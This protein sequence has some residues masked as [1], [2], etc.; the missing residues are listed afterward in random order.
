[1]QVVVFD[2]EFGQPAASSSLPASR[3]PF[4]DI[5]GCFGHQAIGKDVTEGGIDLLCCSHQV[6]SATTIRRLLHCQFTHPVSCHNPATPVSQRLVHMPQGSSRPFGDFQGFLVHAQ[7][8]YCLSRA[9]L[10]RLEHSLATLA[11]FDRAANHYSNQ[12][13]DLFRFVQ[14][15]LRLIKL[16]SNIKQFYFSRT[17]MPNPSSSSCPVGNLPL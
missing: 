9:V 13:K 3:P 1:M 10:L 14:W 5:L 7:A 12:I 4:R 11:S 2:L 15:F 8:R 6:C 16:N 17:S